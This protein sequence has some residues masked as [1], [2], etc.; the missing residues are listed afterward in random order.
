MRRPG[1][2]ETVANGRQ[3]ELVGGGGVVRTVLMDSFSLRGATACRLSGTP[4]LFLGNLRDY[5]GYRDYPAISYL[6]YYL[7]Y[8]I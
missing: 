3:D 8:V 5:L 4:R 6:F 2:S 1:S 7:L